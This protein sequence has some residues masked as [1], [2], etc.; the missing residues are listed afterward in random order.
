MPF[1]IDFI[2]VII[3]L[4]LIVGTQIIVNVRTVLTI[5]YYARTLMKK[6][7][8]AMQTGEYS[9][10]YEQA[11][12]IMYGLQKDRLMSVR[13]TIWGKIILIFLS[14]KFYEI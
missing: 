5:K 1:H 3:L 4:T 10:H 12:Q 14:A 2:G 9:L 11:H 7:E 13:K 8:V 6:R